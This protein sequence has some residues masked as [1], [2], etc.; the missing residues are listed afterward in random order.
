MAK[1]QTE[2][3]EPT[4][5]PRRIHI[6]EFTMLYATHLD[7]MQKAGLKAL[8]RGKEWMAKEEWQEILDKYLG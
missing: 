1:K 6:N 5:L 8:A 4:V 3:K 2:A 7:E